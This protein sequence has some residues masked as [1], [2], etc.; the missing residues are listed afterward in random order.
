MLLRIVRLAI[1][2]ELR[3]WVDLFKWVTRRPVIDE[4]GAVPYS[5]ARTITPILIAFIAVSAI[6]IPILDLLLPWQTVRIIAVALGVWGVIWMVG[7]LAGVRIIPHTVGP[8][9]LRIRGRGQLDFTVPWEYIASLRA[10][11][12]SQSGKEVRVEGEVLWVSVLKQTN[13]HVTF[14]YPTT[15]ELPAGETP[16][17]RELRFAADE[18]ADLVAAARQHLESPDRVYLG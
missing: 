4:P 17:V 6:E 13:V 11:D 12:R 9:G 7:I 15:V 8:S 10:V 3:M 18:P 5:Y 14:R 2:Y 1:V 16:P